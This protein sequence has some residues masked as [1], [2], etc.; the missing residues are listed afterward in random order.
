MAKIELPPSVANGWIFR[1]GQWHRRAD[2]K[3]AGFSDKEINEL[4]QG[5]EFKT[6]EPLKP[7]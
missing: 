6:P 4:H 3:Q 2:L 1:D 7:S 5:P